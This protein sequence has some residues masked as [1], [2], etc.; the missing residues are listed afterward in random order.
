MKMMHFLGTPSIGIGLRHLASKKIPNGVWKHESNRTFANHVAGS[1]CVNNRNEKK[2]GLKE[3]VQDTL[4]WWFYLC[5]VKAYSQG[6]NAPS[7]YF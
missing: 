5:V 6:R 7:Y 2:N 1:L 3:V 4:Q